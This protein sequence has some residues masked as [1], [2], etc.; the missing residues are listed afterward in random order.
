MLVT[1]FKL[2][3][4]LRNQIFPILEKV[5]SFISI[6]NKLLLYISRHFLEEIILLD[7]VECSSPL[8]NSWVCHA[9]INLTISDRWQH[10]FF[11][12]PWALS[13]GF[14]QT[15]LECLL[16]ILLLGTLWMVKEV[17]FLRIFLVLIV[18]R[19]IEKML[20]VYL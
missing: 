1:Y 6:A 4:C 8:A 16:F 5:I 3:R 13:F 7:G 18:E 19:S 14:Q 2:P 11:S 10:S 9:F 15:H 20:I 12:N 17:V